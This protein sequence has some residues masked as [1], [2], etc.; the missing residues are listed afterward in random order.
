ML[1]GRAG[2]DLVLRGVLDVGGSIRLTGAE[3]RRFL[4]SRPIRCR[5]GERPAGAL[6]L[7]LGGGVEPRRGVA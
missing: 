1:K 6:I 4:L 3:I 7:V 2:D 5:C